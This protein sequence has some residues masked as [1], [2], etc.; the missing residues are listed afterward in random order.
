MGNQ[1]I[2]KAMSPFQRREFNSNTHLVP[3][4]EKL[5]TVHDYQSLCAFEGLLDMG[6]VKD[7]NEMYMAQ[8]WLDRE[9]SGLDSDDKR[10]ESLALE[11][12]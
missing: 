5:W 11:L 9:K 1:E 8:S 2:K 7:V 4:E 12:R 6:A 10:H 3:Y